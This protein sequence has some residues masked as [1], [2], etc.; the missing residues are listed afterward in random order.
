LG[1]AALARSFARAYGDRMVTVVL[2]LIGVLVVARLLSALRDR[3]MRGTDG[4]D[5]AEETWEDRMYAADRVMRAHR[6]GAVWID[7]AAGSGSLWYEGG[8][9]GDGGGDFD[10]GGSDGGGG[11]FG[12]GDSG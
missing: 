8:D 6:H 5:L 10:D 3:Q 7:P 2:V 12:G 11:D 9:P 4:V 1:P